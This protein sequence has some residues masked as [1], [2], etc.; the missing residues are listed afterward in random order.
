MELKN[1]G[2]PACSI[3]LSKVNDILDGKYSIVSGSAE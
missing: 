2:F 1:L 3:D